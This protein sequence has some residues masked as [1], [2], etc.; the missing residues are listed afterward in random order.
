MYFTYFECPYRFSCEYF[1]NETSRY[2]RPSDSFSGTQSTTPPGA[3]PAFIPL[4]AGAMYSAHGSGPGTFQVGHGL[5]NTCINQF[6]YIWPKNGNG[7]W[8]WL[9]NIAD[10]QY[11]SGLRWTGSSWLNFNESFSNIEGYY[12]YNPFRP[13]EF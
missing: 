11:I 6:V 3:P 7:Y 4:K 9:N 8:S 2:A 1:S 5:I 12:C 13:S 10:K